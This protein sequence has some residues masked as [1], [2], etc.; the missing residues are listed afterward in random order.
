MLCWILTVVFPSPPFF[1]TRLIMTK[2]NKPIEKRKPTAKDWAKIRAMYLRGETLDYVMEQIPELD[3]KRS[4][5]SEKMCREGINK[6]KREIEERTKNKLYQRVEE[7]KIQ[8]NE[9]HIQLFN[10]SL[11]VIQ[12]LLEQYKE[13][14]TQGKAK[15]RASAYNMDLIMSGISKAQKGLRVALG[16]DEEGNLQLNQPDILV[17]EGFNEKSI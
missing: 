11:D 9:R 15:P 5:I 2:K 12:T 17:I 16:M 7:D 13:E 6:K 1:F 10:E 14:L 3:V 8:A 4:T